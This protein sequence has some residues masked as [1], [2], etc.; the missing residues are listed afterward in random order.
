M[1]RYQYFLNTVMLCYGIKCF[2]NYPQTFFLMYPHK[3]KS[4][5]VK[6]GDLPD[7]NRNIYNFSLNCFLAYLKN[8]DVDQIVWQMLEPTGAILIPFTNKNGD[9]L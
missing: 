7:V 6:S 3:G 8:H 2:G 4:S 1:F 5:R 9:N